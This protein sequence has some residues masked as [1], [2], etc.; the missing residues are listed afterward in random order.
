[1]K[2][3]R[4]DIVIFGASR[5]AQLVYA[6]IKEDKNTDLNPIG[7]CVDA[8][9]YKDRFLFGLPIAKF[10]EVTSYFPVDKCSML[11]AIGYHKLNHL[12][13]IKCMEAEKK[14]YELIS[15]VHSGADVTQETVIGKNCI[16]LSHVSIGPF[17][18]IGNNVCIYSNATVAHHSNVSDNVWITSGT[19]I[20][21]NSEIGENC[22]LG[23]NST[24]GHNIHIGNDNFIGAGAIVM[25]NT[26][27]NSVYIV[28][29]SPKYRLNTEQFL[30]LFKFD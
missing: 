16:I 28:P 25:K 12:R 29:D 21:G 11:V 8:E 18:K 9:Y 1:M 3:S 14:G 26:D 13:A 27:D 30:R 24:I 2:E 5:V 7:F 17:V 10:D 4:K 20:G 15:F 19:T 23:I 22:F 6:S